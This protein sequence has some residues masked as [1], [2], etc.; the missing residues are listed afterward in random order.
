[1]EIVTQESVDRYLAGVVAGNTG[2][3]VGNSGLPRRFELR[4]LGS[5]SIRRPDGGNEQ[6]VLRQSKRFGLLVYLALQEGPVPRDLLLANFWPRLD[7]HAAHRALRQ[8]CHFLREALGPRVFTSS[9]SSVGIC[10]EYL[11]CDV[12]AL[13]EAFRQRQWE[14]VV[15]LYQGDFLDGFHVS[16]VDTELEFWIDEK[17]Q[18]ARESVHSALRE[19]AEEEREAGN[20]QHAIDLLRRAVG[21]DMFDEVLLRQLLGLLD[22]RGD[23]AGAMEVYGR[24]ASRIQA[25]LDIEP[26]IETQVLIRAIKAKPPDKQEPSTGLYQRLPSNPSP[27]VGRRRE[28]ST[29]V[30]TLR[31]EAVRILSLTGAGGIGKTR[32]ALEIAARLTDDYEGICYVPL[33]AA[34][35][36]LFAQ[37]SQSL[38]LQENGRNPQS[39]VIA[40]LT[41][42]RVLLVLD[43]F[44]NVLAEARDVYRLL[45]ACPH[46]R[47]LVT[48][49]C[50]LRIPHECEQP[51]EGLKLPKGGSMLGG[52]WPLNS[53]AVA[54]FLQCAESVSREFSLT[55]RNAES[56]LRVCRAVGGIP[57]AL[58][59]A[60]SRLREMPIDELAE[61][62]EKGI[63]LLDDKRSARP[64]RH[65][66]MAAAIA[67]TAKSLD[68]QARDLFWI[69]SLFEGPFR[70]RAAEFA[71]RK[72]FSGK[73]EFWNTI[74]SLTERGL[75]KRPKTQPYSE[76]LAAVRVEARCSLSR[77]GKADASRRV[78]I[79]YYAAWL[80][81]GQRN[82]CGDDEGKWLEEID[83]EIT[84]IHA[85]LNWAIRRDP[86]GATRLVQGLW[87]YWWSRGLAAQGLEIVERVLSRNGQ[88]PLTVKGKLLVA[89]GNLAMQDDPGE[90]IAHLRD[91]ATFFRSKG[92]RARLGWALQ[93]LGVAL[94]EEGKL[95]ESAQQLEEALEMGIESGND[96]RVAFCQQ[97]LGT[98]ALLLNDNERA[99]G[100]L[101]SSLHL[102]QRCRDWTT[103]AWALVGLGDIAI[104]RESSEE[105][106]E[107]YERAGSHFE[108]LGQ[109]IDV[110]LTFERRA[111]ASLS[112]AARA[113]GYSYGL[114][115]LALYQDVGYATG[116]LQT[117]AL[118]ARHE[119]DR[120]D[121]QKGIKLIAG[122]H[123][124]ANGS[125]IEPSLDVRIQE[126]ILEARS[127]CSRDRYDTLWR[128][129]KSLCL[130][131]LIALAKESDS[132]IPLELARQAEG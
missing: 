48:S 83:R 28:V 95:K 88:L 112:R 38:G 89:A 122:V 39:S 102:A 123:T 60:A 41:D 57:L 106:V 3:V 71:T 81:A 49:I 6:Q 75:L 103:A 82:Y 13:E 47:I 4:V 100:L 111:R 32:V 126:T 78:L 66:T 72:L 104:S 114:R 50:P 33:A 128:L 65:R 87:Y 26:A 53:E 107:Y 30:S 29:A 24:F 84:S 99:E 1:M 79:R 10:T 92:D 59:L 76:M 96:I 15:A 91:A 68:P 109:K 98:L 63:R 17:R 117:L 113:D 131:E 94:R 64:E 35:G 7:N 16:Q 90:G 58:E 101:V 36:S 27:F 70:L 120:G 37:L 110:A 132:P 121:A 77:T 56:I 46:I 97:A 14:K 5:P 2:V 74:G 18:R 119:L 8:A 62:L 40:Q 73:C 42:R 9:K 69:L 20:E 93:S 105:A 31:R 86:K 25:D 129:G 45:S 54:Y 12:V 51:L 124:L 44:E 67:W 43:N 116:V 127:Q 34:N 130:D 125:V 23:R 52:E 55:E 108:R 21:L 11:W 115:A 80:R 85:L 22:E 61:C 118:F 19:F